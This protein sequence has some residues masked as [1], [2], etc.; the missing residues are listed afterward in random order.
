VAF[1]NLRIGAKIRNN[2]LSQ[3]RPCK[4]VKANKISSANQRYPSSP[5]NP[6]IETNEPLSLNG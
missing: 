5:P 2:P 4:L 6:S 3:I 1:Y